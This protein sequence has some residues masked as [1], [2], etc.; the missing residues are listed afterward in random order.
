MSSK[1]KENLARGKRRGPGAAARPSQHARVHTEVPC[2]RKLFCKQKFKFIYT[3]SFFS[4]NPA[5]SAVLC[6][7]LGAVFCAGFSVLGFV[8]SCRSRLTRDMPV[9]T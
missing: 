3:K 8:F 2:I 7:V 6:C 9:E 1:D 4:K 5:Q